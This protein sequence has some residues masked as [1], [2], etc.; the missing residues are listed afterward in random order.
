M[1]LTVEDKGCSGGLMDF[2]YQWIIDNGGIDTEDDY[3]YTAQDGTC[4]LGKSKQKVVTIDS[5]QDVPAN[6][7]VSRPAS[8]YGCTH[9][10]S[11]KDIVLAI[12]R[13]SPITL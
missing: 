3:P 1:C 5:F 6:D 11:C 8:P 2:A 9:E 12:R 13:T 4:V 7:E 10:R